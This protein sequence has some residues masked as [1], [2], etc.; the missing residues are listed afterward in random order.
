MTLHTT[1]TIY[2]GRNL[3][4]GSFCNVKEVIDIGSGS[5]ERNSPGGEEAKHEA[6]IYFAVKTVRCDLCPVAKKKARLDLLNET[7]ILSSLQH[8]NIIEVCLLTKVSTNAS[9]Y[10]VMDKLHYTLCR[11]IKFWKIQRTAAKKIIF[12]KYSRLSEFWN[13]RLDAIC[14]MTDAMSYLH[15]KN[16]LHRDLKPENIG[17]DSYGA[18]KL[19]DFGL[20]VKLD[21]NYE[22]KVGPDQ[23]LLHKDAGTPRYMSPEVASGRPYGKASDMYSFGLVAWEIL[24]LEKPFALMN[25]KDLASQVYEHHHRPK[26][27][28]RWPA[29]LQSVLL[30]SWYN[31][32]RYRPQFPEVEGVLRD[33]LALSLSTK[34]A[35]WTPWI[36]RPYVY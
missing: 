25:S 15:K 24:S 22:K 9:E 5:S 19:F 4:R 13:Q 30:R 34:Y 8:K 14:S 32:P 12:P 20:A 11:K 10:L 7:G 36:C 6:A 16:I 23:Y 2:T 17:F 33:L 18:L 35:G 27:N 26:V 3:G 21:S 28:R 31:N 1:N 29:E